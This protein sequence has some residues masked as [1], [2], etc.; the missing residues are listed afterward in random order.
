MPKRINVP[1]ETELKWSFAIGY[2]IWSMGQIEWQTYEW[3]RRIG[4]DVLKDSLIDCGQFGRRQ[5]TLVKLIAQQDW[6][7]LRKKRARILWI[8]AKGFARFRNLVAHSPIIIN[9]RNP[10]LGF[11]I[12]D[13]RGMK[14]SQRRNHRFYYDALVYSTAVKMQALASEL[15]DFWNASQ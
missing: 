13:V 4:G 2:F 1:P 6:P 12:A 8:K 11:G 3:G 9:Q 7:E 15:N 5:E 10:E 14:G